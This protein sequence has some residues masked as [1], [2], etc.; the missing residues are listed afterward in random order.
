MEDCIRVYD[1][2]RLDIIEKN[3]QMRKLH[4]CAQDVHLLCRC[5]I[6]HLIYLLC[7]VAPWF[8]YFQM[9]K[10]LNECDNL[11]IE[12]AK[13]LINSKKTHKI[14]SEWHRTG[15]SESQL[16]QRKE[17]FGKIIELFHLSYIHNLD[18]TR[19]LIDIFIGIS[20][21]RPRHLL[22]LKC[23]TCS[24]CQLLILWWN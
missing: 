1:S 15:K 19:L 3:A 17:D 11:L 10:Q 9:T 12:K 22:E 7:L 24:I 13:R 23:K 6:Q 18:K 16:K 8:N 21:R 2:T 5:L 14:N 20:M 4:F